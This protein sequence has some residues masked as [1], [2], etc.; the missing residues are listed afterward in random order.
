VR[1]GR[2]GA[3]QPAGRGPHERAHA[4]PELLA[5]LRHL[6]DGGLGDRLATPPR[7]PVR[8]VDQVMPENRSVSDVAAEVDGLETINHRL[9]L[10]EAEG[11]VRI[12]DVAFRSGQPE[13]QSGT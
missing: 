11:A 5:V 3:G 7:C 2:C 13:Y 10:G 9:P 8:L 4:G 6:L 12:L 1:I